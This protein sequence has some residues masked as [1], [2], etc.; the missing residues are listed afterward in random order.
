MNQTSNHS[1][2][3]NLMLKDLFIATVI[4]NAVIAVV[5]SCLNG[6]IIATF[7]A[8]RTLRTPRNILLLGLAVT[9][10]AIS[11]FVE[12]IFCVHLYSY[13]YSS[14]ELAIIT[15]GIFFNG[16]TLL[17]MVSLGNLT[18]I[19]ADRYLAISLHLRYNELVTTKRY[20]IAMAALWLGSGFATFLRNLPHYF[21]YLGPLIDL[22]IF[23]AFSILNAFFIGKIIV[24]VRHH[25]NAIHALQS[26]LDLPKYKRSVNTMYYVIGV[27]ILC[28]VGYVAALV[29]LVVLQEWTET[30]T[31]VMLFA[32]TVM[33][34]NGVVNPLLYCF[35]IKD[36]RD[37]AKA[38]FI[39]T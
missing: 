13:W 19:T 8:T 17:T 37:A 20:I 26:S 33:M 28:Y 27:F 38:L 11:A 25:R 30:V 4:V 23:F 15:D 24:A 35:R 21:Y 6:V 36:I 7:I 22:V 12:Q 39:K 29:L 5:A 3:P 10:M 14:P 32:D 16:F 34:F 31:I 9:D 2:S 1:L 18:I